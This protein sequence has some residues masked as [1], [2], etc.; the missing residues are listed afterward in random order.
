MYI[1]IYLFFKIFC[2]IYL[3][4]SSPKFQINR[5][6][7]FGGQTET[8][9]ETKFS[10]MNLREFDENPP[11]TVYKDPNTLLLPLASISLSHVKIPRLFFISGSS[12]SQKLNHR[13]PRP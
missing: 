4:K 6:F 13:N 12:S 2:E 3:Q 10:T 8:G 7:Q 9:S 11:T 5:I 1:I